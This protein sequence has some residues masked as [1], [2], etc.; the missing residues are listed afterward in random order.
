VLHTGD[1]KLDQ[2]P[3]DARVTDLRA[4]ARL[5]DEGVDRFLPDSPN[6]DVPGV[7]PPER[8]TGPATERVLAKAGKRVIVASFSSHVHRVQQVVEAADANGRVVALVGRSMVRNVG[9]AA[10]LGYLKVPEGVLVD[11]KTALDLPDD[12]VVFMSTGS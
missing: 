3:M 5:G 6:A 9:I 2:L 11:L 7:T 1:F 8:D 12:R 4:F 10:D